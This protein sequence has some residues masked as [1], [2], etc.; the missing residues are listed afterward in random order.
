MPEAYANCQHS[1]YDTEERCFVPSN[2]EKEGGKMEM[3]NRHD[4]ALQAK[5]FCK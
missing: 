1:A 2:A 3:E 5:F 4:R